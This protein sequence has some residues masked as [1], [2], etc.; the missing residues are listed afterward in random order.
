MRASYGIALAGLAAALCGCSGIKVRDGAGDNAHDVHGIPF[1]VKVPWRIQETELASREMIV[2][3][4]VTQV[5]FD[6]NTG[7]TTEGP[8]AKLPT[9]QTLRL[10]DSPISRKAVQDEVDALGDKLNFA[11]AVGRIKKSV[12]ELAKKVG[13]TEPAT[14]LTCQA[15][16]YDLVANTWS[17]KMLAGTSFYYIEPQNPFIGSAS[18]DIHLA[19]DGTL[20]E[21][22][23]SVTD[24]TASTVLSMI[25]VSAF[26]SKV[27]DLPSGATDEAAAASAAADPLLAL[28][29]GHKPRPD[30]KKK[31]VVHV[32]I[33]VTETPVKTLYQL[34]RATRA[35]ET[36]A[37]GNGRLDLCNALKGID[38]TELVSIKTLSG[39][40]E[41][42]GGDDKDAW[43]ISGQL[44][45]PKAEAAD[46]GGK[47][48]SGK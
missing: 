19:D 10:V 22:S 40:D 42:K 14:E 45:P 32:R 41:G 38:Q 16:N 8:A 12:S 36:P 15:S 30:K 27:L 37:P 34:R 11:D 29:K 31:P 33:D 48:A 17:T 28:E 4:T 5:T 2:T 43:R 46:K 6:A 13:S 39:T 7:K 3:F 25:P 23:T 9:G 47:P 35:D 1:Y 44:L 26:L 20:S 18:A 21:S 24:N